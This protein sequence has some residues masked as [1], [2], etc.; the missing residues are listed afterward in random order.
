M[1]PRD[2]R[3]VILCSGICV[4]TAFATG[5]SE[6]TPLSVETI[7]A[8]HIEAAGGRE[9][10]ATIESQVFTYD[11]K[12]GNDAF[13]LQVSFK[14]GEKTLLEASL[15]NGLTIRQGQAGPQQR[16]R[17]SPKGL[18]DYTEPKDVLEFRELALCLSATAIP[19]LRQHFSTIKMLGLEVVNSNNCQ[20]LEAC[21]NSNLFLKL[22]FDTNSGLLRKVGITRLEDYRQEQGIMIPHL[23][24]KGD[25]TVLRLKSAKFNVPVADSNFAKPSV[26][27]TA[28]TMEEMKRAEYVTLLN[29]P[30]Q[31]GIS[32]RPPAAD[33]R[34]QPLESLP[35]YKPE[36]Q[37]PFQVDLRSADLSKL[38]INGRLNDLLHAD[39][40]SKTVWPARVPDG[41]AP[42]HLLEQSK[43]PGLKVR[44]LHRRGITDKGIGLAIIDQT[45]Q[46]DHVE[47]KDRLRSYEELHAPAGAPAQMHGPAVA[48]LAAG[49]TV[50]VAPE[51]DLYYLAETHGTMDQGKF[52]WDFSWLA[53]TIDRV[54]E[55][56]NTLPREHRIRVLSISVG[57]STGQKGCAEMDAA[58][59]RASQAG[60]FVISTAIER[61][62]KLA[63]HGLGR[64]VTKDP[65][66]Y[67]SYRPGSWWARSLFSG[68]LRLAPGER[69]L[70]PMDARTTASPTGQGDY[71]YYSSGGWSWSVPYLAG[72]YALACQ[73]RPDMTP[74]L[75]WRTALKTGHII[76]V[77]HDGKTYQLGNI[78]DPVALIDALENRLSSMH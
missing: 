40:D 25:N 37:N 30:G 39:F 3:I 35:A 10:L 54:L 13:D 48:S 38:D 17:Q 73:A 42:D 50:G 18:V 32:R 34:K 43:N 76:P 6:V 28:A 49:K 22:C 23:I 9:L 58:V 62:H 12:E 11:A 36:S 24:C 21:M 29:P 8:K 26:A 20:V 14:P 78:V 53:K 7:L 72:L 70:V 66:S 19:E 57:W 64:D 60:I 67:D 47:Y 33:F 44:E 5:G 51:A 63:F 45:L 69:L 56:N 41:F 68:Q 2:I 77:E 52:D 27:E 15:P 65:E 46:V 4:I 59:E 75:F 31:L 61:T 16:W 71:V 55:I 74:E 1:K